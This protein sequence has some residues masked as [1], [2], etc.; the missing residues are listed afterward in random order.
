MDPDTE[1][2]EPVGKRRR[3]QQG[4]GRRALLLV[5]LSCRAAAMIK[6]NRCAEDDGAVELASGRRKARAAV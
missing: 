2:G 5:G 1:H 6:T 4:A 3:T